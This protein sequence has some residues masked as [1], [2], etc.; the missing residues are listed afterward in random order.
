MNYHETFKELFNL[1]HSALSNVSETLDAM[2]VGRATTRMMQK[3]NKMIVMMMIV[4]PVMFVNRYGF[5]AAELHAPS[6]H[7]IDIYM[8]LQGLDLACKPS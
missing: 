6:L 7:L 5:G 2:W 4:L 8:R 1:R 3:Q